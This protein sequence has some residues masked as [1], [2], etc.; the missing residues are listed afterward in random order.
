MDRDGGKAGVS[1]R[2]GDADGDLAAVGDQQF[3]E[4]HRHFRSGTAA[5]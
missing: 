1:S 4:R 5:K 3:M 2:A